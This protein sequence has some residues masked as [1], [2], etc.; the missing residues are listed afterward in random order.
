MTDTHNPKQLTGLKKRQQIANANKLIFLWVIVAAIALSICGVAIQFLFR[1]AAFNQSIIGEKA[2]TQTVLS[3]NITNAN[4]LKDKIDALQADSNLAKVKANPEDSPLKVI[5]DA[6]PSSDDRSALASSLQQVVLPKSGVGLSELTTI[7]ASGEAT[8]LETEVAVDPT[9]NEAQTNN[10]N[11]GATG[12]YDQMKNMLLDLER[13]IRPMN[14]KSLSIQGTDTAL[15]VTV[16]GVTYYL[17]ERTVELG[18][19]TVKP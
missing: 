17:P 1:Q 5:L 6:L 12:N 3:Q 2:K 15:R 19:K 11:F 14:V 16:E 10:F 4:E 13:T 8:G 7:N 9:S 18:K